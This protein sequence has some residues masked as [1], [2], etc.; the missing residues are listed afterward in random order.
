M[1][2]KS[3]H[4]AT[5]AFVTKQNNCSVFDLISYNVSCALEKQ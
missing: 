3:I 2:N 4:P 1:I 5:I